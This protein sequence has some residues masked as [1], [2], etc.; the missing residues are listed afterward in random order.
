MKRNKL[1]SLFLDVTYKTIRYGSFALQEE[2]VC[3]LL[4]MV[5]I[6][7]YMNLKKK[8]KLVYLMEH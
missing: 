2:A 8:L 3:T 5:L 7:V 6:D 1:F 4:Y